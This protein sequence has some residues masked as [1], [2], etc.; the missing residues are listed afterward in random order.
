MFTVGS[1]D[2]YVVQYIGRVS[3]SMISCPLNV[4]TL[5]LIE[6]IDSSKSRYVELRAH[7]FHFC[8]HSNTHSLVIGLRKVPDL[9]LTCATCTSPSSLFG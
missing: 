8:A 4:N 2:H 3:T 5:R 9:V 6:I 1:L 7:K